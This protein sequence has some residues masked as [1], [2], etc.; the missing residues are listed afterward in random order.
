MGKTLVTGGKR[1][2]EEEGGGPMTAG[3]APE[4]KSLIE[5][6]TELVDM[7]NRFVREQART[8]LR[9][10]IIQPLQRLGLNL[11]LTIV[12][13]MLI[14]IALIFVAVGCFLLLAGA[15]GYPFAYLA[16]AAAY[17]LVAAVLVG[18]RARS[19]Q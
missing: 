1:V 2:V 3:E 9:T 13:A 4:E 15:I 7:V 12:A 5:L 6:I 11:A 14:A 17:L 8:T 10:A 16:I 19:V 18:L